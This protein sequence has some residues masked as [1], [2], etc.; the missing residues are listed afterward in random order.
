[1]EKR[2]SID[3]HSLELTVLPQDVLTRWISS[4]DAISSALLR[5][6]LLDSELAEL[7]DRQL[8]LLPGGDDFQSCMDFFDTFFESN[9]AESGESVRDSIGRIVAA[10]VEFL[11]E[12]GNEVIA[13]G[14]YL[15]NKRVLGLVR[16]LR[17]RFYRRAGL[18][19]FLIFSEVDDVDEALRAKSVYGS[20]LLPE[21]IMAVLREDVHVANLMIRPEISEFQHF[22]DVLD[23]C[24]LETAMNIV[25]DVMI[26]CKGLHERGM[27]HCDVKS[28]NADVYDDGSRMRGRLLDLEYV[29]AFGDCNGLIFGTE[30]FSD[31]YWH[32][33]PGEQYKI[34]A[35][36]DVFAFGMMI[37]EVYVDNQG[38]EFI[39]RVGQ[40]NFGVFPLEEVLN[41]C[42]AVGFLKF[43]MSRKLEALLHKMLQRD[44][45][46]RPS[47]AEVLE[48][49]EQMGF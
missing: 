8:L 46:A 27:A 31:E 44:Q 25:K 5:E 9:Y 17:R 19:Q 16:D 3:Q 13:F 6:I 47:L 7:Q 34:C 2:E 49:L 20:G 15:G 12:R 4:D 32:R 1:M 48:E 21:R 26:A 30:L 11:E 39:D 42:A 29:R 41:L 22:C 14:K 23:Q 38:W 36:V 28:M 33:Y 43:E 10:T 35:G 37:L 24:D 40:R 18:Q 45:A